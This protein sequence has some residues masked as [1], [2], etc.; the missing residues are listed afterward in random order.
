MFSR[1]RHTSASDV[2]TIIL[3]C[4]AAAVIIDPA[5]AQDA[6]KS[7]QAKQQAAAAMS[8]AIGMFNKGDYKSAIVLFEACLKV[9]PKDPN[10]HYWAASTYSR[11]GQHEKAMQGYRF[12]SRAFP[13]TPA[14]SLSVQMISSTV[15]HDPS[16]VLPRETWVEFERAGNSLLVGASIKGQPFKAIF[17]T[18]AE[19]CCFTKPQLKALGVPEPTGAPDGKVAGVGTTDSIPVWRAKVDLSVGKIERKNFPILV[20]SMPLHA[21]LLGQTFYRGYEYTI[22]NQNKAILFK[23]TDGPA[24]V[25]HPGTRQAAPAATVSSSGNYVYTVPFTFE[26]E[27]IIVNVQVQGKETPMIFDT[28]ADYSL[29]TP[30][31]LSTLGINKI[32]AVPVSVQ[33]VGGS[34]RSFMTRLDSMKLGPIDKTNVHVL[35]TEQA[36]TNRALLGQN[37]F[38]DW[39]YTIDRTS[40]TI[41][42]TKK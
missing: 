22:D 3:V 28:G 38:K 36:G 18:G 1:G 30:E 24:P 29:F 10:L 13:G 5:G 8:Q 40:R 6:G 41:K 37:F 12:I 23:R 15:T 2:T 32:Q 4:A 34:A 33:G 20:S 42:F 26:G 11:M 27:S 21:P 9:T 16:D 25:A 17:D 19:A 39:Y 31:I 7:T 14:A 35:V